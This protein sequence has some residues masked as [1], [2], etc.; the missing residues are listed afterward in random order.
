MTEAGKLLDRVEALCRSGAQAHEESFRLTVEGAC[1]SAAQASLLAEIG[2]Q[3]QLV[4]PDA[5]PSLVVGGES[6]DSGELTDDDSFLG[7]GW[8]FS[9]GKAGLSSLWPARKEE[10]TL[11]F[12]SE[13]GLC[14]WLE[15]LNPFIRSSAY[16]PDFS[17]PVTIR[18]GDL[19]SPV[20][21]PLLWVL[22]LDASAPERIEGPRLPEDVDVHALVHAA[23]SGPNM[24]I[25][26][27]GWALTWGA[28]D[29]AVA[30]PLMR[31]GCLVLAACL[32]NDI[33]HS[34]GAITAAIRGTKRFSLPL[35]N[36]NSEL[37]W[38]SLHQR[39]VA[40]VAWVYAE[41]PET[42]LKLLMD[43]L[44]LDLNPGEC[45]LACLDRHLD[46]AL[47]QAEDSYPFVILERKDAYYKELR[48]LM[49]DMKSQSD[50]YAT[51]ARE[52]VSSLLRDL[53]GVLAFIAFSFVGKFD[54]QKLEGLLSSP[55]LGLFLKFLAGYLL[56]SIVLQLVIHRRDDVLTQRE[57]DKWLDA[58][59]NYTSSEEK[60]T[61]F[62]NLIQSR[63]NT[64]HVAMA[65]SAFI[66]GCLVL[67]V[68]NLPALVLRLAA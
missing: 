24:R 20:G 7:L 62:T 8:S 60:R 10:A 29:S 48:D 12:F 59:R 21:G 57:G 22:P 13:Q 41:R 17:K 30:K 28:L 25:A 14:S 64:L 31:L 26:P 37:A 42:R 16:D 27:K 9:L 35:W 54:Q 11:F 40:A 36:A 3:L 18:V 58:L 68:W 19:K 23:S 63:R 34:E 50:H 15:T 61:S 56:L 33:K 66:Y 55:E 49:K 46:F 52:L 38:R 39:L 6:V 32:A 1:L 4:V 5:R 51:K 45:F 65:V 2:A 67:A 47:K 53:L 43:R 44:S